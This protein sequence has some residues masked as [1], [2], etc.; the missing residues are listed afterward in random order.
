M[1]YLVL[2]NEPFLV[3]S[4]DISRGQLIEYEGFDIHYAIQILL[5]HFAT[6]SYA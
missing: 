5:L 1:H 6:I 3:I 2:Q 4:F